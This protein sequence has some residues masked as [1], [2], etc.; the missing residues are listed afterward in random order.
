MFW[1]LNKDFSQD[2]GCKL[3]SILCMTKDHPLYENANKS[4]LYE[5]G[6]EAKGGYLVLEYYKDGTDESDQMIIGFDSPVEEVYNSV[7]NQ[8]AIQNDVKIIDIRA[9]DYV[10]IV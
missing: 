7:L 8:I 4:F 5:N 1:I 6:R 3:S 10:G 9:F 2:W